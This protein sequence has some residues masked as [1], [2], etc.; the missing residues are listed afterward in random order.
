MSAENIVH[1]VDLISVIVPVYNVEEYLGQCIE[2]IKNQTYQNLEIIL[3]D[4]GSTDSSGR[5]CD[6]AAETD[7]RIKVI[8]KQN[9]GLS[10]ARNCGIDSAHGKYIFFIDSDDYIAENCVEYLHGL[11]VRH[12]VP[13]SSAAHT[14]FYESGKS[15]RK[16]FA[17]GAEKVLTQKDALLHI[18]LDDGL[19]LCAWNKLYSAELFKEIRYPVPLAFEDTATTYRLL[20]LCDAIAWGCEPTYNYRIR[21]NSITT[22]GNFGKKMQL[23]HN[24]KKMC[25]DITEKYP[26]LAE[27]AERRLVWAYF[28]TL[29][30]LLKSTERESFR[31]EEKEILGFLKSHRRTIK[32]G[33]LYSRRDKLAS[34]A[35]GIGLPF[36]AAVWGLYARLAKR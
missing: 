2:S 28:S 13:L 8:H 33:R 6:N 18:L 30:Q 17:D 21:G 26:E 11:A 20:F 22:S 3:I 1:N 31:N 19:D 32:K 5:L 34:A 14:V 7:P 36:Y 4:D 27:A 24:T 35:L 9:G 16:R 29:N 15:Y 25:D 23:I 10:D 12:D